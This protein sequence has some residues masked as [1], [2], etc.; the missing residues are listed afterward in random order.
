MKR[1]DQ[2]SMKTR[3]LCL[4]IDLF[5]HLRTGP[6]HDPSLRQRTIRWACTEDTEPQQWESSQKRRPS[7]LMVLRTV[8]PKAGDALHIS[9]KHQA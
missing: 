8:L 3:A 9:W 5:L 7:P 2:N 6:S 1:K 4:F